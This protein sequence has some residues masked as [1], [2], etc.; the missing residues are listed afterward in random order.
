MLLASVV[1]LGSDAKGLEP[2]PDTGY[3]DLQQL[4][5]QGQEG[6]T[7]ELRRYKTV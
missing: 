7:N 6:E 5:H 4:Y 2:K 1:L 3:S